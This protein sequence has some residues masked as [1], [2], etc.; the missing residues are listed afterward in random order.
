MDALLTTDAVGTVAIP[1]IG[2]RSAPTW[3]A[4]SRLKRATRC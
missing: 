2:C 4:L 1:G 3:W